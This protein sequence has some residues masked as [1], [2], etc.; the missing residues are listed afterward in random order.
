MNKSELE[1]KLGVTVLDAP[2]VYHAEDETKVNVKLSC[3]HCKLV[4]I[5]S[6]V[7]KALK[8]SICKPSKP[9]KPKPEINHQLALDI[10]F[11]EIASGSKVFIEK[12]LQQLIEDDIAKAAKIF[13][14]VQ[15][16]CKL[17]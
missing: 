14:R 7:K 13:T 16:E 15:S 8:C 4:T 17:Q 6:L 3:E 11:K 10:M 12:L 9:R 1:T 5:K 2:V